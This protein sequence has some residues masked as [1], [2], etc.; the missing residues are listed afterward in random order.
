MSGVVGSIGSKSGNFSLN[1]IVNHEAAKN[2][3]HTA[4]AA[5]VDQSS[6]AVFDFGTNIF[7][8]SNITEAGGRMTCRLAG[9]YWVSYHMSNR[10]FQINDIDMAIRVNADE[11]D[12]TRSYQNNTGGSGHIGYSGQTVSAPIHVP[13]GGIVDIEGNG[14]V[15]GAGENERMT[16]FMGVR[17]GAMEIY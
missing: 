9:V 15:Y 11:V 17:I 1:Q 14:N 10:D 8:G 12:G 7:I 5:S 6:N 13:A 3:W 4:L 16:F 2:S